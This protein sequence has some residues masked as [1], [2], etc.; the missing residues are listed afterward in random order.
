MGLIRLR[1]VGVFKPAVNRQAG[2]TLPY[3]DETG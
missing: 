3:R 2:L 1:R